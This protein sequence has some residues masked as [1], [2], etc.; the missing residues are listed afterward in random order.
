MTVK[1]F[2]YRCMIIPRCMFERIQ[3]KKKQNNFS[4]KNATIFF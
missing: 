4:K 1:Q 3:K 2:L